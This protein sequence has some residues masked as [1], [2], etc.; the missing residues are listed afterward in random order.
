MMSTNRTIHWLGGDRSRIEVKK[1]K[2]GQTRWTTSADVVELVRVLLKI[3]HGA[4]R[5]PSMNSAPGFDDRTWT[6]VRQIELAIPVKRV[7]LEQSCVAGQMTPWM[8]VFAVAGVIE[9]HRRRGGPTE[10]R[11]IPDIDPTSIQRSCATTMS[12]APT[13]IFFGSSRD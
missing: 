6:P 7:G 3:G 5:A 13:Q 8:L 9:H 4:E 11:V 12:C 10:W 2:A 1:N